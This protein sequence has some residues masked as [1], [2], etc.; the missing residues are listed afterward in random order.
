MAKTN[1]VVLVG[2]FRPANEG[3]IKSHK[4]YNLPLPKCGKVVFHDRISRIVLIAE[5]YQ[6]VAYA[7][8]LKYVIDRDWLK[9]EGYKVAPKDAAH[10]EK[11]ALYELG[12]KLSAA[13]VLSDASSDVFV[14][15][16]RCPNIKID[17]AFYAKPYPRTGGKSMPYIFDKL[18]PYF[19]K[20]HSATTFSPVQL[21]FFSGLI[22]ESI[23]SVG[24]S[25]LGVG[26]ELACLDFFAGSGLVSV[27]LS[28][29]FKTVWANDIS[30][31]K[32]RVF[33]A[34][35]ADGVLEVGSIENVMG[36][37][38]PPVALSWGS[39]PCQ[40]LSLAG[41][42]NGLYAS[43]SGLFWQWLRVM[44][45]MHTRPPVVV[46]E[47]VLG[48]VSAEGG[49]YYQIVHREL[50][51]RGYKVGAIMLDAVHWVPQSR[52]RIFVVAVRQ[53]IDTAGFVANGPIWCHPSPVRNVARKVKKWIWWN[54]PRPPKM[55]T[56]L[57]DIIEFDVPCDSVD[58]ANAKLSLISDK[59]IEMVKLATR[60]QRRAFTGYRRT[61]NHKQVL[62]VRMDGIAGCL[63]T[64][65]G[66][67]SRQIV[68]IGKKG[69]IQTRLLTVRETARLMGAPD[70]FKI[71]GSYNDGYM[72]M[73]DG[74]A[75]PV[76]RYLAE[77]LL[78]P[79]A[80]KVA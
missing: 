16:S 5:G 21:D 27:A 75:V 15:S 23:G 25:S 28:D 31:K 29:F 38:L 80:S 79:L 17:A 14:S 30:E 3:W 45:E 40:D 49:V 76:A 50:I 71:P 8:K 59:K 22:K 12:E 6:T 11:Y 65:C 57:E 20:W 54:L 10:G 36:A 44:D 13:N 48:L 55:T 67:S 64:P 39:F 19:K 69:K 78:A 9:A 77:H 43:R 73:G 52:K 24:R 34:N 7:A 60:N 74:V 62:E 41:D 53:D 72:A 66:G 42:M 63:R 2:T 51:K 56:S 1:S 58:E 4:L 32:A 68:V 61:R 18:K 70:D 33:N 47:N 37:N 46:A 35:N 26:R